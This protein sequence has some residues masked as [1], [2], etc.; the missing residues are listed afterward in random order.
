MLDWKNN[1]WQKQTSSNELKIILSESWVVWKAPLPSRVGF[2]REIYIPLYL[3][4]KTPSVGFIALHRTGL[5][6]GPQVCNPNILWFL[7][8]WAE[9]WGNPLLKTLSSLSHTPP[10]PSYHHCWVSHFLESLS[11]GARRGS[12][13]GCFG[14]CDVI[15]LHSVFCDIRQYLQSSQNITAGIHLGP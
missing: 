12:I 7:F 14:I 4:R 5:S 8:S 15:V 2:M 3:R 11:A 13:S 1:P 6:I 10:C 9:K